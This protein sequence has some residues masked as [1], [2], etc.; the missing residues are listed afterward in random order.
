MS[1]IDNYYIMKNPEGFPRKKAGFGVDPD[2]W[3]WG[4]SCESGTPLEALD[5]MEYTVL[6][7]LW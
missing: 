4:N 1:Q 6:Y 5:I 3:R 2:T 7:R